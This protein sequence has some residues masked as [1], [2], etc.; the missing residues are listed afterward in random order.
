MICWAPVTVERWNRST[1]SDLSATSRA[2][3]RRGSWVVTPTGQVLVWQRC[4]WM[5]PTANII[6]RAALV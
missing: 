1:R 2:R 4:A 3:A 5:Q 6:A